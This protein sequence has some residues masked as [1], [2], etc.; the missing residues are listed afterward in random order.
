MATASFNPPISTTF[1]WAASAVKRMDLR[2]RDRVRGGTDLAMHPTVKPAAMIADAILDASK[3]KGAVL[4]RF[5]GPGSTLVA[6]A[7]TRWIAYGVELDPIY[8]DVLAP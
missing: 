7:K 5:S 6:A 4:D 3:P 2:R 1:N 8:C